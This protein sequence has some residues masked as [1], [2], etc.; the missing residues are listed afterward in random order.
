MAIKITSVE[1]AVD[2]TGIKILVHGLAGSGKTRLCATAEEP[3]LIL[4]AEGGLLSI[5]DAGDHIKTAKIMSLAEF[6]EAYQMLKSDRDEGK[7]V[8]SLVALDSVTEIAE[9]VLKNELE[10]CNDPRKSYPA[11]QAKVVALIKSFR[12][13]AGYDVIMTCKQDLIKDDYTGITLRMPSMPGNK[14]GPA[15]P[16]LFD[17]VFALRV[18]KDEEGLDYRV[19]QTN[20]DIMFEAKDRSG[21]LNVFERPNL[22]HIFSKIRGEKV[23]SGGVATPVSK[24]IS[25]GVENPSEEPAQA[26]WYW[27]H[28]SSN[29]IGIATSEV[30]FNDLCDEH[31]GEISEITEGQYLE[32]RRKLI[33]EGNPSDNHVE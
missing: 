4:S 28:S 6:D 21:S 11:F 20:R 23:I 29:T 18:E 7:Q 22:K 19:I 32:A 15:V 2:D 33:E 10:M 31:E 17:E 25:K 9:E 16:Y 8:F 30:E 13:L 14:L 5:R 26:E 1:E 27:Y 24:V 3:T 12:N